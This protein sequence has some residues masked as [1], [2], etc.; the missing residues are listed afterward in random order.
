MQ[1]YENDVDYENEQYSDDEEYIEEEIINTPHPTFED[2]QAMYNK[3]VESQRFLKN[4]VI[5]E[6]EKEV[7]SEESSFVFRKP[8]LIRQQRDMRAEP[9]IREPTPPPPQEEIY[10]DEDMYDDDEEEEDEEIESDVDDS[11]LLKRLEEKYGKLQGNPM[12]DDD[13][14]TEYA[15][16]DEY[17]PD[18]HSWTSKLIVHS[19]S[20]IN[21]FTII[22]KLLII[23][24]LVLNSF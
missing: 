10:E 23:I 5:K 24:P 19:Y 11:D 21:H 17:D 9:P 18:D 13:E 7:K 16:D 8:E 4:D 12:P 15:Y 20:I 1:D 14:P 3:P 22:K 2:Y 6:S